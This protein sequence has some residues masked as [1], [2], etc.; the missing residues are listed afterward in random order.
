VA[1][2]SFGYANKEVLEML[3]KRGRKL[4]VGDYLSAK[5]I[6]RAINTHVEHEFQALRRPVMAYVTFQDQEGHERC[7]KNFE[8][9]RSY[10]GHP[11][12]NKSKLTFSNCPLSVEQA[13]EPTNIIWENLE[14]D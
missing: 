3:D 6:E 13:T 2:V 4:T 8:T 5:D 10:A 11:V 14:V 1:C 9:D 7:L 12:W